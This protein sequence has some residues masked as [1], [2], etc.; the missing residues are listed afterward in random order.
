M[1]LKATEECAWH[2]HPMGKN[3]IALMPI[4]V[5]HYKKLATQMINRCR[6]YLQVFSLYDIITYTGQQ[7]HPDILRENVWN[8][9]CLFTTGLISKNL[10]KGTSKHGKNSF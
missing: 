10:L 7:I 9:E 5:Q 3:D 4:A 2:Q 1:T 8:L 6:L